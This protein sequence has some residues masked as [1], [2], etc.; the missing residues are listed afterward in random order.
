MN[1]EVR[2]SIAKSH[3]RWKDEQTLPSS[4]WWSRRRKSSYAITRRED[5]TD[6]TDTT[7]CQDSSR[8]NSRRVSEDTLTSS[9]RGSH[10]PDLADFNPSNKVRKTSPLAFHKHLTESPSS[11]LPAPAAPAAQ[12]EQWHYLSTQQPVAVHKAEL[13]NSYVV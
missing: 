5:T 7:T 13:N 10:I 2:M 4:D 1:G 3:R 11:T 6:T 9:R 8:R 12:Q